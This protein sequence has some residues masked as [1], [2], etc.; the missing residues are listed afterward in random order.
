[1]SDYKWTFANVGGTTRV[2]LQTAEDLR[3]LGE[4]DKKM[5]TI[6]S[7]PVHGL[8]IPADTLC[9]MDSDGDGKLRMDEIVAANNW[10]CAV[11]RDPAVLFSAPEALAVDDIIDKDLHAVAKA[12]A[13]KEKMISLAAVEAAIAAVAVTPT[14]V[15]DAPYEA[16]V[17]AAYKAKRAEYAAYYEQEKLQKL[18][19]AV[20]A[21][22]AAK[23]GMPEK[24]F[25]EMG[26]KIDAYEAAV[27]AAAKADADALAAGQAVY[28]PLL[29][30]LKLSRCFCLLLRNYVTL[31]DFFTRDTLADFQC[32]T[33]YIDQRACRLCIRVHDAASMSAMAGQ[34]K[35]Y[36][37]FCDCLNKSTGKT[38]KIVAAMTVGDVNSLS[39]G[40]NAVFYDR[41]G[42][43]YD[44][45]VTAIIENPISIR[46][47][48]WS[49]Y[50]RLAKWV[51][52][53]IH[54][55]AAEKDN[56]MMAETTAKIA[57]AEVPAD[58]PKDA[59]PVP[60]FD[61]AKFAGIFAAI[62]MAVGM[63]GTA[64]VALCSG[65]AHLSW[66]QLLLVFIGLMLLISGPSMLMAYM[67][68][69]RRNL[70]PILNA[71]GWA[72]NADAIISVPFGATL[73]DIVSYPFMKL[74]DPF[75]KKGMATWKKWTIAICVIL[76]V[77]VCAAACLYWLGY[78]PCCSCL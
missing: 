37:L 1:M 27:A 71:N 63:I 35:M 10:L 3:H 74:T 34:S 65:L 44:A 48:F 54:K 32:G 58:A 13:G 75:A 6:L 24:K 16:D 56:E 62:G 40:K 12:I 20:I 45:K 25:L 14:P 47:A 5:W 52:D 78:Y 49:P 77:L 21:E 76:V 53:L 19:L 23:P 55:R 28:M 39:V 72:V 69:R 36:L 29:K 33:L 7:C 51:E 42:L 4:L 26:A 43:D 9:L 70:A 22:D 67:K 31:E 41:D 46:Q 15:P 61:I 11:L 17:I 18:G 68:L 30:L 64:L 50:R 57:T 73:T 2:R 60:P 8:E 38:M 66:W 59:K